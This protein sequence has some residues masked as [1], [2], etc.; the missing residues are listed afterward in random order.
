MVV[1]MDPDPF[2][3][4]LAVPDADLHELEGFQGWPRSP[5]PALSA[6]G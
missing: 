4:F 5:A 3:V 1:F 2:V 6:T